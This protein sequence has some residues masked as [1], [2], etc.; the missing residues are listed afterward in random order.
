MCVA[1]FACLGWPN[2]ALLNCS[3]CPCAGTE[4]DLPL[5]THPCLNRDRDF[6]GGPDF[7]DRDRDRDRDRC[8]H[9]LRKGRGLSPG[10][11]ICMTHWLHDP[12]CCSAPSTPHDKPRR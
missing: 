11:C 8:V 6:R 7:R 5:L 10:F 12:L 3:F 9:G 4:L 2:P 1:A